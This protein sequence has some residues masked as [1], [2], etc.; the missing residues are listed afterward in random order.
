MTTADLSSD[1]PI[2]VA[3][4]ARAEPISLRPA[5]L[6]EARS[7]VARHH[8]HHAPPVGHLWSI[9]AEVDG[10]LVGVV[11]VGRPVAQ[12][13]QN[14]RT[15][16]VTRLCCDGLHRN[17]ASRLLGAAWR[18]ASAMGITRLVSYLRSDEIGTCYRAAG[19]VEVAEVAGRPWT[20]GNKSARLLPGLYEP[21]S[22]IV[23]RTRWEKSVAR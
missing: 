6:R 20:S 21:S 12:G 11:V 19:W 23:D 1:C 5:T 16:E 13:L 17:T 8:S 18:A 9:A 3:E 7:Y 14:P 10:E 15:A 4:A 2:L 22:E